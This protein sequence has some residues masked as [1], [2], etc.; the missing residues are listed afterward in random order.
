MTLKSAEHSEL[1]SRLSVCEVRRPGL[2]DGQ[3]EELDP[4]C[5]VW[6]ESRLA[7]QSVLTHQVSLG[8]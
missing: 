5:Q 6:F 4:F 8:C 1:K 2:N 7:L 3:P